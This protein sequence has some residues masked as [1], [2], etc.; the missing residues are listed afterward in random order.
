[1]FTVEERDALRERVLGFARDDERVVAGA[2]VGS[3]AVDSADRFSD[4]DLT[5]GIADHVRVAD[6]L[7]EWTRTRIDE[8]DAVPLAD[9]V[10]GPTT[11][12][13]FLLPDALQGHLDD[14]GSSV[15][16]SRAMILA[17]VRRDGWRVRSHAAGRR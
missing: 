13:V 6:V 16:A 3:L 5:F 14:A 7:D 4:V 1:M 10:R 17:P 9:L 12:R 8:L 15:P 11:Y 2:V